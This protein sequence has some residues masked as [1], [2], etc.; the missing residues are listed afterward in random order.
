MTIFTNDGSFH[1]L[2][3]IRYTDN[4]IREMKVMSL[5]NN[6]IVPDVSEKYLVV[7]NSDEAANEVTFILI[8]NKRVGDSKVKEYYTVR[9][10][11]HYVFYGHHSL[12]KLQFFVNNE[13]EISM[14]IKKCFL[15]VE[16]EIP[17]SDIQLSDGLK[18]INISAVTDMYNM[19]FSN[20]NEKLS[21]VCLLF[22][23]G[24]IDETK[25]CNR[26]SQLINKLFFK[27]PAIFPDTF[28]SII[29]FG[30]KPESYVRIENRFISD[31][32]NRIMDSISEIEQYPGGNVKCNPFDTIFKLFNEIRDFNSVY[33]SNLDISFNI[34]M[35]TDGESFSDDIING[36]C[37]MRNELKVNVFSIGG[38]DNN[39]NIKTLSNCND[40]S[41]FFSKNH[42]NS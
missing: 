14:K 32:T 34:V 10:K 33:H 36:Y 8:L 17:D 6:S 7:N 18:G 19:Y 13:N 37:Q 22:D 3:F 9:V 31:T 35:I 40:W 20:T 30:G 2:G 5:R 28:F 11:R 1:S 29:T 24:M 26:R 15:S 21:W 38:D 25:F 4:G 23:T 16:E 39:K 12:L 27:T 42:L 41:D